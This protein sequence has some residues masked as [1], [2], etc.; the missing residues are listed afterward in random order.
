MADQAEA[1]A[2]ATAKVEMKKGAKV[3]YST[4]FYRPKTLQLEKKPKYKRTSLLLR[5]QTSKAAST[6]R[7]C[8]WISGT[9][10]SPPLTGFRGSFSRVPPRLR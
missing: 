5:S 8:A 2:S 3:R 6:P 10:C 7:A 1:A 9:A 4:K